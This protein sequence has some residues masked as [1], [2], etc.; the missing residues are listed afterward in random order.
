MIATSQECTDHLCWNDVAYVVGGAANVFA[1]SYAGNLPSLIENGSATVAWVDRCIDLNNESRVRRWCQ[2]NGVYSGDD[3]LRDADGPAA[4]GEAQ[5]PH[6]LL[7]CRQGLA[8]LHR[9]NVA[10][11]CPEVVG[12]AILDLHHSKVHVWTVHADLRRVA[13][14]GTMRPNSDIDRVGNN[15][16]IRH[17]AATCDAEARAGRSGL[18]RPCPRAQRDPLDRDHLQKAH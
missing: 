15:V 2:F 16:S 18:L 14:C 12:D 5:R 17:D 1:E 9:I 10:N 7:E 6:G 8:Q 13:L 4:S 11:C 3:P